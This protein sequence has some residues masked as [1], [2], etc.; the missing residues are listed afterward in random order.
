[1]GNETFYGDGL[2]FIVLCNWRPMNFFF[3]SFWLTN[4]PMP[5]PL[6]V[7]GCVMK[8]KSFECFKM[9][10]RGRLLTWHQYRSAIK[11]LTSTPA[12]DRLSEK[13]ATENAK[14][15]LLSH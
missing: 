6:S 4:A 12:Q 8:A 15:A 13:N 10:M 14:R 1:M 5:Q 2:R 3:F 11:K 9:Q 7:F